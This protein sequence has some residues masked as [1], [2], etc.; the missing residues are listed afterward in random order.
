MRIDLDAGK[1]GG[2]YIFYTQYLPI[3]AQALVGRQLAFSF[4]Q[5]VR[6]SQALRVLPAHRL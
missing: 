5:A 3:R 2:V 1:G 4:L 6:E